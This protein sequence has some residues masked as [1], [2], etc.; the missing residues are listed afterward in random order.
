MNELGVKSKRLGYVIAASPQ[1]LVRS[2]DEFNEVDS[3]TS[4]L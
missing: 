2:P 4:L 1:L 3:L